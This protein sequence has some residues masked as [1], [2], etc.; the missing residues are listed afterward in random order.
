MEGVLLVNKPAGPTSFDVVRRIKK[1]VGGDQSKIGHAGT[2]DP[3]ASGL[4][5]ICLG[6]YTK[7]AS[8]LTG[9][10]KSYEAS[11][12]LGVRT[13]TD[14]AEGEVLN[15]SNID[16][17]TISDI[18][19]T[20]NGFLGLNQQI[21][22]QF[23]AVKINGQ[24]AYALARA[25]KEFMLPQKTIYFYQLAV[26]G[27]C[28]PDVKVQ[29][30]CSKGTYVRSL[31]RD[32][33]EKLG[34]GAYAKQI[35]RTKS[36]SYSVHDAILYDSLTKESIAENLLMGPKVIDSIPIFT[37]SKEEKEKLKIGQRIVLPSFS[38]DTVILTCEDDIV[39][40]LRQEQSNK[41]S[42]RLF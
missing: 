26:M 11:I 35:H 6:R 14:D 29:I 27:F 33:G 30:E 21:P 25:K 4:L 5:V 34:V 20:L 24:R 9:E 2:L 41:P 13:S 39:A 8:L 17:L 10:K 23:S 28:L 12:G 7:L 16:H 15:R 1:L 19:Q 3:L 18:T 32:L 37:I 42:F 36:G 22:P 40:I 38:D 31:A